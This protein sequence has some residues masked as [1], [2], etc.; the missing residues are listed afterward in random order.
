VLLLVVLVPAPLPVVVDDG[1]A[2]A[3]CVL[4]V[5][6]N[7]GPCDVFDNV[8][9]DGDDAGDGVDCPL[10]PSDAF[11]VSVVDDVFD[12]DDAGAG[13]DCNLGPCDAFVNLPDDA[14]GAGD[15]VD[16]PL[17][18]SDAFDTSVVDDVCDDDDAG[19]DAFDTSD[20]DDADEGSGTGFGT[21]LESYSSTCLTMQILSSCSD[22]SLIPTPVL[23][24]V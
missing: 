6:C 14:D 2:L 7:L 15:G 12:D 19:A 18:P 23:L 10:P 13:V 16:C 17:P 21:L 20:V 22:A 9:D 5:D 4:D 11:D 24:D 3:D 1:G 8:A